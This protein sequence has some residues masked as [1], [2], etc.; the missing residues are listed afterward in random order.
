[1]TVYDPK[2]ETLID[3]QT[4]DFIRE[5]ERWYPPDAVGLS[6]AE[7]RAVYDE[8]CRAFHAGHP[9]GVSVRDGGLA[10]ASHTIA[11]RHYSSQADAT[12][13]VLYFH[14]GGFVVGGLDS[15][16]DVCAEICA[17]TGF[18]VT[19][20]DYRLSPD[21]PFPQDFEDA[22]AVARTQGPK[23]WVLV[24]DSAGVTYALPLPQRCWGAMA[25]PLAKF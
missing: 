5:T 24:G 6:I 9:L 3:A 25:R 17:A 12:A 1:M 15:H 13:Q 8:M 2:Y 20:V 21:C 10:L 7:Q 18:D 19:S 22:L 14:G 16:D 4:W 23:P 11:L